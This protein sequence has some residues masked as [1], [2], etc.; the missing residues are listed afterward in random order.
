MRCKAKVESYE[1]QALNCDL[2]NVNSLVNIKPATSY[3][4]LFSNHS[5]RHSHYYLEYSNLK[6]SLGFLCT[7][8]NSPV[9]KSHKLSVD[10]SNNTGDT[11]LLVALNDVNLCSQ[12]FP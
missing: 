1:R 8:F 12:P 5:S 3:F 11:Y 6:K 9:M 7:L 2:T 4:M 10:K